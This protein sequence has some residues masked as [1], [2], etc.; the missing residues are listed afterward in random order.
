MNVLNLQIFIE[1]ASLIDPN[2]AQQISEGL[3]NEGHSG[4]ASQL[5]HHDLNVL[6]PD[7]LKALKLELEIIA[8]STSKERAIREFVKFDKNLL[9]LATVYQRYYNGHLDEVSVKEKYTNNTK[10]M[11]SIGLEGG[12]NKIF[13][14]YADAMEQGLVNPLTDSQF[15]YNVKNI[16][17]EQQAMAVELDNGQ[18]SIFQGIREYFNAMGALRNPNNLND[19]DRT[20]R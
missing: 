13:I 5:F 3:I 8:N 12:P 20:V 10:R 9:N 15:F 7:L 19:G 18:N 6:E 17:P 11:Y 14:E 1:L 4:K 16:H 2:L